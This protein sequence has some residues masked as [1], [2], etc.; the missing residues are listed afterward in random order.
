[1]DFF[2]N[3]NSNRNKN[4][5]RGVTKNSG[6][7]QEAPIVPGKPGEHDRLIFSTAK[8]TPDQILIVLN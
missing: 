6:F 8:I 5:D 4:S 1:M 2:K 7:V 3:R